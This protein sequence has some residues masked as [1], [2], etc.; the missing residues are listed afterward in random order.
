MSKAAIRLADQFFRPRQDVLE[1]STL[2]SSLKKCEETGRIDAFLLRTPGGD[3]PEPHVFWDSDVAK[4][5]EGMAYAVKLNPESP[6]RARLDALVDRVVSAQQ[7]DGYLNTHFTVVEKENRWRMLSWAHEL[8]CAGHLIEAAVAHFEATGSRKF[9]DAM[10]RYADYIGQVFGRGE[11]Q[12]RGYPGH[13]E[14][15]LALVKLFRATGERKYLDL[16]KYF[17]DERGQEPHYF[18]QVE[19]TQSEGGLAQLQCHKPVREQ[20][21]AVGHAVRA[22]YLYSGMADVAA[23]TGDGE[24]LAVCEKLFDNIV[25]KKMYL[26]GGIGSTR[27]GEAFC[28]AYV[29][30]NAEAYAESCASIGMVFFAHR[31]LKIT[32]DRKYADVVERELYNGA[33]SGLS[34]S[35]SEFFYV[36][37]LEVGSSFQEGGHVQHVRQKWFGC[38][39]CPTSYCRFIPQLQDFCFRAEENTLWV[40]IPAAADIRTDAYAAS[41]SGAYP[42]DG[43]IRM[44]VSSK[45]VMTLKVRIMGFTGGRF[46]VRLNGEE[47]QPA[48]EKGYAVISRAF[49]EGDTLEWEFNMPARMIFANPLVSADSGCAAVCRGPIVYAFETADNPGSIAGYALRAYENNF[50]IVP[51]DG[52]PEG[53]MAVECDGYVRDVSPDAPLYSSAPVSFRPVRLKG[54]PYALWQNRA[55]SEMRVF[56]PLK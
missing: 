45:A 28:G 40:D 46:S 49:A 16:A 2:E 33:I 30:P 53:T 56:L 51:A 24:L 20:T 37:P 5:M 6:M 7:P 3:V 18:S 44:T 11:G 35:G 1:S 4:V 26:T 25:N 41:I 15:E 50:R 42:Y 8:Y 10:C 34:L 36:N 38:S 21:E 13:E 31:M 12:K 23:L 17:V 47:L 54:I 14:L 43:R 9:L 52:L 22:V 39:C 19:K 48:V 29:L 55:E 27:H 32:G